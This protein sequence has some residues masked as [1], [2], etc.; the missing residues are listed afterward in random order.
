MYDV[1]VAGY[2]GEAHVFDNEVLAKFAGSLVPGG[3]L[4]L[5]E[6]ASGERRNVQLFP[7][8]DLPLL[9]FFLPLALAPFSHHAPKRFAHRARS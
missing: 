9:V 6:A 4:R 8:L 5:S 3:T 2:T 1:I 7:G